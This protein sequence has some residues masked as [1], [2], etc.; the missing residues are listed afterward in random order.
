MSN[1][2]VLVSDKLS[3]A[4]L[5]VLREAPGV[6]L[7]FKPG[8]SED[9]LC[10]IVG[11][12]DGSDHPLGDDRH[13]PSRSTLPTSSGPSAAPALVSTTSTSPPQAAAGIVVMNTPTG[14]SVTTAEHALA[15]L[16]CACK[17]DPTGGR[18]DA[19]R[20]SGRRASSRGG[21]SRT[22]HSASS[23]SGTSAASLR[24]ARRG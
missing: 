3:E 9:E 13:G 18:I 21:R 15:L 17:E 4:G 5:N 8:M 10:S 16:A 14:N 20:E 2:R 11:E 1:V 24:T 12:F 19:R 6:E 23:V 7:E 22:R